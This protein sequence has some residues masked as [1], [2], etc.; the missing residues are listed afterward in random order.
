MAFCENCGAQIK[1]GAQF[2]LQ[3]GQKTNVGQPATQQEVQVPLY[4]T[5]SMTGPNS[6]KLLA[7]F[8]VLCCLP[9]GVYASI[10]ATQV[11]SLWNAGRYDEAI[12]KADKAENW[13]IISMVFAAIGSVVLL[14]ILIITTF[15]M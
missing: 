12:A 6:H 11:D 7:A 5:S 1:D 3:C 2:C 8:S 10:Q 14:L 13:A 9:L 4:V 15:F